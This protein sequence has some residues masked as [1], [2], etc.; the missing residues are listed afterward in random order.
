ME[1]KEGLPEA[2]Y[3]GPASSHAIHGLMERTKEHVIRVIP[4]GLRG[5]ARHLLRAHI[6]M[7]NDS[8]CRYDVL[9]RRLRGSD[10]VLRGIAAFL[11]LGFRRLLCGGGCFGGR[12]PVCTRRFTHPVQARALR[13]EIIRDRGNGLRSDP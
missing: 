9:R 1:S 8:M 11:G 4:R 7:A 6:G 2:R 5:T 12:L 10:W 3:S 13:Y